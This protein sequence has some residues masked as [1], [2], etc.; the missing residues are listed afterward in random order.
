MQVSHKR[1]LEK[2]SFSFRIPMSTRLQGLLELVSSSFLRCDRT[3]IPGTGSIMTRFT[4]LCR[5]ALLFP[6]TPLAMSHNRVI[7]P[8]HTTLRMGPRTKDSPIIGFIIVHN[9]PSCTE[10]VYNRDHMPSLLR[11]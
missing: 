4:T 2:V 3:S 5:G 8:V 11:H 10:P 6:Q 1:F 9:L 7:I